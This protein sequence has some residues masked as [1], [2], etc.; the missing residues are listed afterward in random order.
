MAGPSGCRGALSNI[1]T[2]SRRRKK[3]DAAKTALR[4]ALTIR[5]KANGH[6]SLLASYSLADLAWLLHKQGQYADARTDVPPRPGDSREDV[7][8]DNRASPAA[9]QH[10][11]CRRLERRLRSAKPLYERALAIREKVS[12]RDSVS[13]RRASRTWRGS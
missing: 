6:D 12:G 10:R 11:R 8:S 1:A 4:A 13:A 2:R 7:R 3:Y 5:E 9:Q